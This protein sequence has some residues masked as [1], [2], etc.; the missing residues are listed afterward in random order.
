MQDLR[1]R[2]ARGCDLVFEMTEQV[3]IE[4]YLPSGA[5]DAARVKVAGIPAAWGLLCLLSRRSAE[6]RAK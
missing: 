3:K 4:G 1:A 6:V 2:K 5:K